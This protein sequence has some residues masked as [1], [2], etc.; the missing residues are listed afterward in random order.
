VPVI[1]ERQLFDAPVPG[2][3]IE[4]VTAGLASV[5]EAFKNIESTA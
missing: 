5:K 2:V 1:G 3:M 4:F